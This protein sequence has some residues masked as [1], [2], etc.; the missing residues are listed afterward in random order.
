MKTF[1][2]NLSADEAVAALKS[3][4]EETGMRLVAH[5][6][7]Q[8]NARLIGEAVPADQILEVFHPSYAVR[9]WRVCKPA[10]YDI[11]L[12]IHVY[13]QDGDTH[14]A[15]RMPKTV[16]APYRCDALNAI[17]EELQGVF[18]NILARVPEV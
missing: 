13:E 14:I 17:A 16:F 18:E 6:N 11:P 5:I 7:G 3:G 4:I 8:A 2:T 10:G 15:C 1:T 9:L 12:R